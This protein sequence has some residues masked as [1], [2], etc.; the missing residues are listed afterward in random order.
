MFNYIKQYSLGLAF[1]LLLIAAGCASSGSASSESS[2]TGSSV[3]VTNT[4]ATLADYLRRVSGVSVQG[5][6]S[7]AQ[8]FVRG[9][10]SAS[11]YNQPLF[12]IDGSRAGRSLAQVESMVSV[13][14]IE[15]IQVLKGNEASSRYGLEGSNGVI[16]IRTKSN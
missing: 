7:N 13:N 16:I 1:I 3:S 8:V 9:A 14:D 12:I 11:S 10:G 5:S 4:T 15:N 2:Q 6:G